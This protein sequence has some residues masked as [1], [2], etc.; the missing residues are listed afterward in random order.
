MINLPVVLSAAAL[1]FGIGLYGVLSQT[2]AI[3]VIMGV[4]LLLGASMLNV[5]GFLRYNQ[6]AGSSGSFLVLIVMTLMAVEA[7]VGFALV[8][9]AWRHRRTAELD[10]LTELKG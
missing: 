9:S 5:V 2:N 10:D 3:M 7:A 1:L 8:V 4:E 6:P